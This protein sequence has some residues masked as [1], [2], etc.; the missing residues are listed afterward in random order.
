[1]KPIFR[2]FTQTTL[3]ILLGIAVSAVLAVAMSSI[4]S[5][6]AVNS[7]AETGVAVFLDREKVEETQPIII[8]SNEEFAAKMPVSLEESLEKKGVLI[9]TAPPKTQGVKVA[10]KSVKVN[11]LGKYIK[12][13][14]EK[15][16]VKIADLK[17]ATGLTEQQILN[18][19]HGKTVPTPEIAL[20]FE[21]VLKI[22][23]TYK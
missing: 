21:N 19:E 7:S 6:F 23:I 2:F 8:A 20:G 10:I 17:A 15:K 22:D 3:I 16:A 9:N 5:V 11:D 14:C 1:M 18:I 13:Q 4:N 12:Q